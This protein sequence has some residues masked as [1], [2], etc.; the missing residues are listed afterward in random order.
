MAGGL[1]TTGLFALKDFDVFPLFQHQN[2]RTNSIFFG[3]IV[4]KQSLVSASYC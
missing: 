2:L 4:R 1:L 3:V